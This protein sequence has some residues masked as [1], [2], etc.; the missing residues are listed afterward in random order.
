MT[1]ITICLTTYNRL[2]L[3]RE[4]VKSVLNQTFKDFHLVIANDYVE[5]EISMKNLNL[6]N[7]PRVKI[8]N[9]KKNLGEIDNSNNIL[10]SVSTE[11]VCFLADDDLIHP[12]F[13]EYLFSL[14]NEYKN[15]I[16]IYPDFEIGKNVNK[17]FFKLYKNK[18]IHSK[19]S[20]NEFI[21]KYICG[22]IKFIGVYGL[23]KTNYLKKV[24][25]LPILSKKQNIYSDTAL[26][27]LLTQYGDIVWINQQLVFNRAHPLSRSMSDDFENLME[28][29]KNY[30]EITNSVLEEISISFKEMD[31]CRYNLFLQFAASQ[32][33]ILS[34][35]KTNFIFSVIKFIGIQSKIFK[36]EIS[37]KYRILFI[38]NMILLLVK[39]SLR[40]IKLFLRI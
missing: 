12:Q 37:K 13:L 24:G 7:D 4:S 14:A 8:I 27:V 38:F 11:W 30:L 35:S 40:R 32:M 39:G 15:I 19:L 9:N 2:N 25:G 16:A 22:E 21:K 18:R 10:K 5:K 6:S 17:Q 31:L 3:L 26:P 20:S 33:F 36:Y 1:S 23:I 28:A 29:Q 34:K